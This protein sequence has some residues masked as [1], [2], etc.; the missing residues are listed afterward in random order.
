LHEALAAISG[1]RIHAIP[2]S[3]RVEER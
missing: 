2:D 3:N 1:Q